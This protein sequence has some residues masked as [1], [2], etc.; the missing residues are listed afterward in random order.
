MYVKYTWIEKK[1]LGCE[2]STP[3]LNQEYLQRRPVKN[4]GIVTFVATP[5]KKRFFVFAQ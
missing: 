2:L 1:K 5:P 4:T 3:G